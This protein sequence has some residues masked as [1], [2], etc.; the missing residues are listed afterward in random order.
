MNLADI[1]ILAVSTTTQLKATILP[2]FTQYYSQMK[3]CGY[4]VIRKK[5]FLHTVDLWENK[6]T[7]YDEK[8][9]NNKKDF[10]NIP[11]VSQKIQFQPPVIPSQISSNFDS[12]VLLS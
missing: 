4:K 9:P 8:D 11:S 2:V 1:P 7:K 3:H 6:W 10:Q 5:N 12:P